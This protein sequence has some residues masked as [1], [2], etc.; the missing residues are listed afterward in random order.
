MPSKVVRRLS[1]AI[2]STSASG[3][4]PRKN[5]CTSA[6][7]LIRNRKQIAAASTKAITWLRVSAETAAL[8]ASRPPAI[9]KL[10]M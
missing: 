4:Q 1:P 6:S 8:I 5:V 3:A 9:S 7:P 10:P 2:V